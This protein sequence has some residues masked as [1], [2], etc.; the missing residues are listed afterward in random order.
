MKI[1]FNVNKM[2]PDVFLIGIHKKRKVTYTFYIVHSQFNSRT[3]RWYYRTRK[4]YS[5][6]QSKHFKN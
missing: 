6:F 3:I 4:S 1:T 2:E 5:N